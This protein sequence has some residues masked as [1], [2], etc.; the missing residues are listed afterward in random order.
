MIRTTENA[1]V[2]L[3]LAALLLAAGGC[4]K[5]GD[6]Q[7]EA[8]G[9]PREVVEAKPANN[10]GQ[11]CTGWWC[12]T[13]GVPEAECGQCNARLAADRKK[14]GDWCEDHDR[15]KSQCFVCEPRLKEKF[16]QRYRDKYG[17]E[18]PALVEDKSESHETNH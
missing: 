9:K 6:R 10:P 3:W 13:H 18:P 12:E 8:S 11:A 16:A 1:I 17:K 14:K 15:P 5:V 2:V 4:G 7:S